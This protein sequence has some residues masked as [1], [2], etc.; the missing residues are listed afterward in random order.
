MIVPPETK[1][2]R[3]QF[4]DTLEL[5]DCKDFFER[6][7]DSLPELALCL[8]VDISARQEKWR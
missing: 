2:E 4:Q 3:V 8:T 1:L 5:S 6:V 7:H